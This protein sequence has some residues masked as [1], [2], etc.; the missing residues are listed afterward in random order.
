MLRRNVG[1]KVLL[2]NNRIYGLTK[3]Q[4]SPT[5]EV[6]KKTKS[7]PFGSLDRPF[8]P[9]SL[10]I[11]AEATFVAR[12]VDVFQGHLKETLSMQ[13]RTE[14][15]PSLKSCRTVIFSTMARGFR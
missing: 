1:L 4:Y 2:F 11:G 3:G 8:N 5:S 6:N 9:V 12:S 10:A 13:Q 14:A 7:T 15:P